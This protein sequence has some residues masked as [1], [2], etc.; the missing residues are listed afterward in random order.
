MKTSGRK[1]RSGERC[2][3]LCDRCGTLWDR[4]LLRLDGEGMLVCPQ[5]GN[6]RD[7]ATLTRLN[8]AHAKA[9]GDRMIPVRT[10]PG[11][12][13]RETPVPIESLTGIILLEDGTRLAS[14]DD[15]FLAQE[16]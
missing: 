11:V 14:E 9:Y 7:G 3:S 16:S 10:D 2:R 15:F 4:R 1:K 8:V 12:Y 5:E 13:Q 6:G